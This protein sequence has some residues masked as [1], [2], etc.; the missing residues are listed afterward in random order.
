MINFPTNGELII[1]PFA[2]FVYFV[3][4]YSLY[5]QLSLLDFLKSYWRY[6]LAVGILLFVL[7]VFLE[8]KSSIG[9][10]YIKYS[11]GIGCGVLFCFAFLGLSEDKFGS[12]GSRTRFVLTPALS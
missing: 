10:D 5:R 2:S 12:F 7:F 4:G 11:V 8:S 1:N 6:Y 3:F 9:K